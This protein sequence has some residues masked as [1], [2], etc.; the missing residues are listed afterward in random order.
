MSHQVNLMC[1]RALRIPLA[2]QLTPEPLGI[3]GQRPRHMATPSRFAHESLLSRRRDKRLHPSNRIMPRKSAGHRLLPARPARHRHNPGLGINGSYAGIGMGAGSGVSSRSS[4]ISAG[5]SAS[6]A[7]APSAANPPGPRHP[8][9][10]LRTMPVESQGWD[11]VPGPQ[12]HQTNRAR[13]SCT[14]DRIRILDRM[15]LRSVDLHEATRCVWAG[16]VA[17]AR[18]MSQTV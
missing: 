6:P 16:T 9:R 12:R 14:E 11:V 10:L 3:R 2:R 1:R 7:A 17:E 15:W 4:R 13:V 8:S 5:R 18:Q